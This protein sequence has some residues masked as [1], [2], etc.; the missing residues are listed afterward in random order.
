MRAGLN[1]VTAAL[2]AARLPV[3]FFVR[4]DDGGWDDARLFAL[5]D[6]TDRA[7]V[8]IDLALIP[9]ASGTVLARELNARIDA[10]PGR[11][12]V[13]QH[14]FAH[15]NHEALGRKCEFGL[16]RAADAQRRD[17]T[18]GRERL[19]ALFDG[20]LDAIFTPPWNRCSAVTPPL[21]AE[22][23]F[24]ALSRSRAAQPVQHT[25]PE[26]GVSVDWCKQVR[27]AAARRE[28]RGNRIAF[29]LAEAIGDGGAVG[30]MLHHAEMDESELALLGSLIA[31]LRSHPR[32]R[33]SSMRDVLSARSSLTSAGAKHEERQIT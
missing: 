15:C 32:A 10:A 11:V 25:L 33:W 22:L 8:P 2:D 30:L 21:L 26:L 28:D 1:A 18:A 17:L 6:C 27:A 5:L 12:S 31:E 4:D 13:H 20:R 9:Q 14:G 3:C 23:G 24:A 16:S 19:G 7:G 29:E